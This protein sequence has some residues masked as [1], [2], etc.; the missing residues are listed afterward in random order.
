MSGKKRYCRLCGIE[1]DKNC[2]NRTIRCTWCQ[3]RIRRAQQNL[4]PGS[5]GNSGRYRRMR[6]ITLWYKFLFVSKKIE[7]GE[8]KVLKNVREMDIE[9]IFDLY[10]HRNEFKPEP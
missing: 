3:T 10:A 7:S 6:E 2:H 5:C 4:R 9:D 8:W 1:L